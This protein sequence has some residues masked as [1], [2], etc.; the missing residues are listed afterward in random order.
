MRPFE[1]K[2]ISE[3]LPRAEGGLILNLL[4]SFSSRIRERI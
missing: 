3:I 1:L 4:Y 2:A